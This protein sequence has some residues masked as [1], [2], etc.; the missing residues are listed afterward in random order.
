MAVIGLMN[1]LVLE[2]QKYNI[3]VNALAPAAATRMT[4]DLGIDEG[5]LSLMKPRRPRAVTAGLLTLCHDKAPSRFIL[6]T[7]AGGYASTQIYETDGIFSATGGTDSRSDYGSLVGSGR[8]EGAG[9][10][11]QRGG[12]V[13]EVFEEGYDA[14]VE[15]FLHS[16][17]LIGMTNNRAQWVGVVLA[18]T[19]HP[20][21]SRRILPCTQTATIGPE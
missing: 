18:D 16:L 4:E 2:G 9:G 10:I 19:A 14:K 5:A 3:H 12:A 20:D 8:P 11:T 17:R 15:R 13:G 7:G 1:T 21:L 6:C